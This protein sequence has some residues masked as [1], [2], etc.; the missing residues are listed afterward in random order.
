[1]YRLSLLSSNLTEMK[2]SINSEAVVSRVH[3]SHW[4]WNFSQWILLWIKRPDWLIISL[5]TGVCKDPVFSFHSV[6]SVL[7]FTPTFLVIIYTLTM[8]AYLCAPQACLLSVRYN[9]LESAMLLK[10]S[11][12]HP[13]PLRERNPTTV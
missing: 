13:S 8:P 1:M 3:F 2:N 7:S 5:N 10:I 4:Y 12:P 9:C 6:S 11:L